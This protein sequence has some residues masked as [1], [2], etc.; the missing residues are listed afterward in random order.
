MELKMTL[1]EFNEAKEEHLRE[2]VEEKLSAEREELSRLENKALSNINELRIMC[3]KSIDDIKL[4][5]EECMGF[6]QMVTTFKRGHF[7]FWT[8]RDDLRQYKELHKE[9]EKLKESFEENRY[10]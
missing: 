2:H 10:V 8:A 5:I 6:L 3:K 7:S 9:F 4:D 1:E